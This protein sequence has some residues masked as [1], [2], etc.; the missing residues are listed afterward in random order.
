MT[1]FEW[2]G[3][4]SGSFTG[5][6]VGELPVVMC[7]SSGTA[8][9]EPPVRDLADDREGVAE[10]KLLDWEVKLDPVRD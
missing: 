7:R 10:L 8:R 3:R 1:I 9:F 5:K 4:C 2:L 6:C